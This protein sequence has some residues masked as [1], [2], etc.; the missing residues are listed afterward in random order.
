[1][2]RLLKK[3]FFISERLFCIISVLLALH[4]HNYCPNHY[5]CAYTWH[6]QKKSRGQIQKLVNYNNNKNDI[7]DLFLRSRENFMHSNVIIVKI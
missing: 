2:V 3:E 4:F 1:M 7:N 6:S 5:I